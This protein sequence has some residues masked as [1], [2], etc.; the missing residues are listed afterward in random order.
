MSRFTRVRLA[1]SLFLLCIAG[2]VHAAEAL[3]VRLGDAIVPTFQRVQLKL[4]PDKRNFAGSV[5]VELRVAR[6]SDTLRFHA[7]GQ[8]LTRLVL[9]QGA[10]TMAFTRTTGEHGLQTLVT[11]R[12]L[13]TG[14]ATLEIE[15]THLYGTRAVG[16]YRALKD[17]RGYLFTQFESDDARDLAPRCLRQ[18]GIFFGHD[19]QRA[20]LGLV[21][22]GLQG[23]QQVQVERLYIHFTHNHNIYYAFDKCNS[24]T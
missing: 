6:A 2:G 5:R 12:P 19:F 24:R 14:T 1:L 22:Q 9:R 23:H 3:D 16:L 13:A 21:E 4:D 7:E 15:F 20:L 17:S 11:A 8:R 18:V 10:D